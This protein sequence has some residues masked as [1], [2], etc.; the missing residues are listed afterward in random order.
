M[1]RAH[2]LCHGVHRGLALPLLCVKRRVVDEKLCLHKIVVLPSNCLLFLQALTAQDPESTPKT[3]LSWG[4]PEALAMGD[5]AEGLETEL[6][7]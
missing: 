7:V 4:R 5:P 2:S 6:V 1:R 3:A